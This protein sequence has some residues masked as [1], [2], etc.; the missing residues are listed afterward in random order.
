MSTT[1]LARPSLGRA[2]L[3]LAVIVRLPSCLAGAVSVVLGA[4]LA[5]DQMGADV[6]R[7]SGA[8]LL[9]VAYANVVND[10]VDVEVDALTKPQRPLPSG[11]TSLG[12][13]RLL[14]AGLAGA[15][16]ALA[17]TL[18][19]QRAL[20]MV[21]L[22]AVATGYSLWFKNSVLLGNMVV[23]ACASS[24]VVFGAVVAGSLSS[25]VWVATGLGFGFM[26]SYETLKTLADH[27]GDRAGGLRTLATRHGPDASRRL[28]RGL[29][30]VVTVFAVAAIGRSTHPVA[31]GVAVVLTVVAPAGM[32]ALLVGRTDLRVPVA[33]MRLA[34]F[35]GIV[36]LWLLR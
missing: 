28:F 27:D 20:W 17:T 8:I 1:T 31:Y 35:A 18:G 6:M 19:P 3:D 29:V 25:V 33:L 10:V 13:A 32:A 12:T 34:W 26:V 11:R 5:T 24:P 30:A 21:V 2:L 4:H 14:A 9:A 36:P 22:V 15:A 23:A 16:V 7:A